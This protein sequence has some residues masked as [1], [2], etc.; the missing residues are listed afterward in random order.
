MSTKAK[1]GSK[2]IGNGKQRRAPHR[3]PAPRPPVKQHVAVE[4]APAEAVVPPRVPVVAIGASAGGLEAFSLVLEGLT[5]D[6]GVALVFVQHLAPQ[7][8][9]ALPTLLS[10]RT[11]LP[12]VQVSEG[13]HVE[14]DHVYVIP[15]NAQMEIRDGE[16]H[17]NPRPEDRTQ[18]TP[19]DFFFRSLAETAGAAAIG[20]VLSGSSSDGA[21]G[22]REI[23]AVGGITIAQQPD[24]AR[25]DGMPRAAIAT[26][27]V[28]L[29]LS[30]P[31]IAREILRIGR[32]P[33]VKLAR[34]RHDG[35]EVAIED[36]ELNQ[37]I[38]LL[39]AASGI[40]F[41]HYKTPTIKRRLQRRMV[42]HKMS[43]VRQ[44]VEF[45]KA[46]PDEGQKLSQ[47]EARRRMA[48]WLK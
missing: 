4:E 48:R 17:L 18:Y 20:V 6:P 12:V 25:Y 1:K 35:D 15:P 39:R 40:D 9:S 16:L 47:D 24:T 26:Q 28:D 29:V 38:V 31:D 21:A 41:A 32:H 19:I 37:V 2:K 5:E 30:P 43:D 36:R 3:A 33:Y 23:K 27:M 34:P 44:Y 45:L 46:T 8:D 7:H 42:L 11:G 14:P 10:V 13:T 22:L